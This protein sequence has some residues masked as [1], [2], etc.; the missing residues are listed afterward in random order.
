MTKEELDKLRELANAATPGPWHTMCVFGSWDLPVA[1]ENDKGMQ[2]FEVQGRFGH[3]DAAFI[4][5][6]REAVPKLIDEVERL[7]V[8]AELYE[9]AC[10][11]IGELQEENARL[12]AALEPYASDCGCAAGCRRCEAA[13][14][15]LAELKEK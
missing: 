14:A 6:S 13:R 15:A 4:A 9:P 7:R 12:R 8:P 5:A 3:T 1:V 2:V 11:A 10:E